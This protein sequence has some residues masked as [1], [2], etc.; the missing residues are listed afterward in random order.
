MPIQTDAVGLDSRPIKIPTADG[1]LPGYQAMPSHG[2]LF[3]VVLVVQE[4]FGVNDY[5]QDVCR[6]LAKLGYLA[7]APEL[8]WRQGDV[9]KMT[10]LREITEKVVWQVPDAQVM[11]DLD[12]AADFATQGRGDVTR[13]GIT[14]F[15]WGGRAAWLYATHSE[16]LKAAVAWYGRLTGASDPLHPAYPIDVVSRLRCPVLGLYGALDASIPLDQVE[17]MRA[18]VAAAHKNAEIV[19]Y[20]EAGHAFHADYRDHYY[21]PAAR[22][23]WMRMREWFRQYGV[24]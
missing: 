6:R 19:V 10:N 15:C 17:R 5:I 14:G 9:S 21:E 4:I 18:A 16:R 1:E 2:S 3:P 23:G 7:L 24:A 13:I 22:D 20:P 8:Y 12:A 11:S